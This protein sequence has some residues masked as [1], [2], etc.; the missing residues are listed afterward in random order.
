MNYL[1]ITHKQLEATKFMLWTLA[2]EAEGEERI[3]DRDTLLNAMDLVVEELV[4]IE[5]S[6]E[7]EEFVGGNK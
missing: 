2:L 1:A 7:W 3:N 6:P 5:L 4:R